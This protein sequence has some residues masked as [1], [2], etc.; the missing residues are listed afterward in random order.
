MCTVIS[1]LALPTTKIG[2]TTSEQGDVD[3]AIPGRKKDEINAKIKKKETL[4]ATL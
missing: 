1:K 4:F 2:V 3:K